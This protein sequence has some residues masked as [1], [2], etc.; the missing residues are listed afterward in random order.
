MRRSILKRGLAVCMMTV[1][2]FML[3]ATPL[4]QSEESVSRAATVKSDATYIAETK[5]FIKKEGTIEDARA[6]CQS[7]GNGWEV[8]D[9]D[10]NA[11]TSSAMTKEQGVFLCYR[12]TD[13]PDQAI[14]D[15]A[16]MNERGNYSE[17]EYERLL[18]DQ[19]DQYID[20]VKNMRVMIDEYRTNYENNVSTAKKAHDFMNLYKE[21]D[22]GQL[23]GDLLLTVSEE[24]LADIL[25]QA[26]GLVILTIQ[27]QL[28]SACDTAKTTWLDRLSKLGGYDMLKNAFSKNMPAGNV[29]KTLDKQYKD[30][31]ELILENWGDISDRIAKLSDFRKK[32]GLEDAGLI[33]FPEWVKDKDI[34]SEEFADFQEVITLIS[35]I[36][37]DYGKDETV[38][39]L[40]AKTADEIKREGIEVL[41]P[42]AACLS[43]GQIAALKESVGIYNLIQDALGSNIYN[44]YDAGMAGT[45]AKQSSAEDKKALDSLTNTVEN[46]VKN[47]NGGEKISIYEGVD[48]EV[49]GGGVAVTSTAKKYSNGVSNS[50][51][52]AFFKNGAP[53]ALSIAM[54]V[55]AATLACTAVGFA[56]AQKFTEKTITKIVTLSTEEKMADQFAFILNK[57]GAAFKNG[58]GGLEGIRAAQAA[59]N[60]LSEEFGAKTVSYINFYFADVSDRLKAF[61]AFKTV[62]TTNDPDVINVHAKEV[63]NSLKTKVE[64][65]NLTV[66]KEVTSANPKYNIYNGLKWG[67]TIFTIALAV[68]DIVL[69]SI[70]MYDYYHVEH[71]QIPHHMVDI[72]YSENEEA[73]YVAYKS[74]RDQDGKP[75]DLNA[76]SSKQ[77]LALY[78]TKDKK[79]GSPIVAPGDGNEMI[80]K[81]GDSQAPAE[82]YAPLHMFGTPNVAQNLT[83]ADGN[84][85]YSYNDKNHG[86]YLFFTHADTQI[87]YSDPMTETRDVG[88][89]VSTGVIALAGVGILVVGVFIGTVI[90]NVRRRRSFPDTRK[91]SDE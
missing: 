80:V 74:V 6:W 47:L 81:T 52:G 64:K 42:M 87:N 69:T 53:G 60:S 9:G 20:I 36:G 55:G 26:N 59:A 38:L 18:K 66:T 11:G 56:V 34:Q 63:F 25:L 67:A 13:D 77:W 27:Q 72:S 40:F 54:G 21:D 32:Y 50:W 89:A 7:Q 3:P 82:G 62:A 23:L 29:A 85:G 16:V 57:L 51:S 19:R 17:G 91:Q 31:A 10:L 86:T 73:A 45:L 37:Y 90:T 61:N 5:L 12:T 71:I 8:V 43:K 4:Y 35:L 44:N 84:N 79:A 46:T 88:T 28:A 68:T 75:G 39:S 24:K 41:Y 48:R 83:F 70:A 58:G 65:E 1:M 22:S 33:D 78:C 15:L 2:S 49:F 30:V 76:G 14:T